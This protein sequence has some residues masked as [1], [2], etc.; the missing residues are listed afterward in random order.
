MILEALGVLVSAGIFIVGSIQYV[1]EIG[2]K[3]NI[4]SNLEVITNNIATG[5]FFNGADSPSDKNDGIDSSLPMSICAELDKQNILSKVGPARKTEQNLRGWVIDSGKCGQCVYYLLDD[6][7][8]L[9]IYGYGKMNDY[10]SQPWDSN[11][12]NI[13]KVII[14]EGVTSIRKEAFYNCANLSSVKIPES[15]TSI[16][17]GAFAQCESLSSVKIPESVTSIG[18]GAFDS[19][20][21]LEDV[22]Y[23]GKNEIS[24]HL[25]ENCDKLDTIEVCKDYKYSQFGGKP[26]EKTFDRHR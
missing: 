15:V 25:F 9:T 24:E 6:T 4:E 21:N 13:K 7:G 12:E 5:A 14:E 10:S 22:R 3:A 26:V 17:F 1:N 8:T 20:T 16:G 23:F 19:C 2:R 18:V 11:R